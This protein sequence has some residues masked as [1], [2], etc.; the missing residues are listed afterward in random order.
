MLLRY[1]PPVCFCDYTCD[2]LVDAFRRIRCAWPLCSVL[3]CLRPWK[4]WPRSTWGIRLWYRWAF[5]HYPVC[6]AIILFCKSHYPLCQSSFLVFFFSLMLCS[7]F[8]WILL[9]LSI[10]CPFFRKWFLFWVSCQNF[11]RNRVACSLSPKCCWKK[12][13]IHLLIVKKPLFFCI[14]GTMCVFKKKKN[15][16]RIT[17]R[18]W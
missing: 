9:C 18:K 8:V 15:V 2:P 4:K 10:W 3:P 17:S 11:V 13:R 12:N 1:P 6:N 5:G 16:W 14:F 7:P